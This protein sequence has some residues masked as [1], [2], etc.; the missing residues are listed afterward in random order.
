M[1]QVRN[2]YLFSRKLHTLCIIIIVDH[3][4]YRKSCIECFYILVWTR[5][6]KFWNTYRFPDRGEEKGDG[7]IVLD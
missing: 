4:N 2:S 7:Q 6:K 5:E 1:Y 3:I